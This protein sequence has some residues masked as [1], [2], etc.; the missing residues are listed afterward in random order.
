MAECRW[1]GETHIKGTCPKVKAIEF[2][3]NGEVKRVE[4]MTPQDLMP[5]NGWPMAVALPA[6]P[7]PQVYP[8]PQWRYPTSICGAAADPR[9]VLQNSA[10]GQRQ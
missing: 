2:F 5:M 1:C 3:E 8:L 10:E 4:F 6:A 7:Q 9:M